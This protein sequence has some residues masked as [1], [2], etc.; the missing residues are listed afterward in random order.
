[1]GLNAVWQSFTIASYQ[2]WI[3]LK[4]EVSVHPFLFLGIV[5]IAVSAWILYNSE[6]RGG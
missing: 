5:I 1:M 3:W 4:S 6:V 2:V